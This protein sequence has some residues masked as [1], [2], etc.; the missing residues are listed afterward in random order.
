MPEAPRIDIADLT[1]TEAVDQVFLLGNIEVRQKKNGEPFLN[2]ELVDRS[3][4]MQAKVWDG[5]E[6]TQRKIRTGDYV[7]V[8]GQVKIYNKRLDMAIATI[9]TVDEKSVDKGVF[10]PRTKK[11][12]VQ[13][14]AAWKEI[15][16]GVKNDWLKRLLRTFVEDEQWFAKFCESPA[17]VR[18]HHACIG[19]LLEHVVTL[20]RAAL[21][22]APLYPGL[23][24]DLLVTGIFL[25]DVGKVRELS[26][27]RVFAYTDEGRLVGHIAIGSQMLEEVVAGI[28]GFP[29][30]LRLRLQH[31][32]L[33]HHG[34][35]EY[36]SP[37]KP[38]TLEAVALHYL[39]NLDAKIFAFG[40][41]IEEST[42]GDAENWTEYNK[43]F[44][45]Y[46]WKGP[47]ATGEAQ[48]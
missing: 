8:R 4:R 5:A 1:G 38:M 7:R 45:G 15:V 39:D 32:I 9:I 6:M 3:G 24:K 16:A 42:V 20:A 12:P 43:M 27:D 26:S 2:L 48:Q 33:A 44:D 46:L 28:E 34:Q 13:L 29:E 18:L 35:L 21:A 30:E 22:I 40:K 23:D 25:H 10:V 17:A 19:G 31:M 37:V 47:S 11:D 36:G 14:A 41:A